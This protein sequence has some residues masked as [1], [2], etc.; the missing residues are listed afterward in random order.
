MN[1]GKHLFI[2][3]TVRDG[4]RE[5]THRVL[6]TTKAENIEFAVQRYVAGYWGFP[7]YRD[8]KSW[9]AHG[10][11]IA[12]TLDRYKVLTP[13]QYEVMNEVFYY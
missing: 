4:E 5:H 1:K 3:L 11:E 8:G 10:S 12:I 9:Y 13:E 6:H 7:D 2:E